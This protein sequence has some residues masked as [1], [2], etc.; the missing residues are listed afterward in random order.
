MVHHITQ[1]DMLNDD[2]KTRLDAFE[3]AIKERLDDAAF[4]D[5]SAVPGALYMDEF[6]KDDLTAAEQE[7]YKYTYGDGSN[8]PTDAEYGSAIL[9]SEIKD[10]DDVD[11][12]AHD[13]LL[14]AKLNVDLGEEGRKRGTVKRRRCDDDGNFIGQ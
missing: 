1:D 9:K 10:E 12:D 5:R 14:G 11:I 3:A 2:T 6:T 13:E 8:T 4:I 7:Y